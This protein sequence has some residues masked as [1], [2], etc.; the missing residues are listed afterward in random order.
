VCVCVSQCTVCACVRRTAIVRRISLGGEGNALY[1]VLSCC[2]CYL[3]QVNE[4]NGGD[5]VFIVRSTCV[6]V[7]VPVCAA[8]RLI[9]LISLKRF[10]LRTSNLRRQ[11]QSGHDPLKIF[12]KGAWPG[13]RDPLN[14]V[15]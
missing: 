8:E 2:C 13:S 9:N 7:Y 1:P 11:G 6:C 14:F 3:R 4:V 15:A 5:N 12:R 10:K